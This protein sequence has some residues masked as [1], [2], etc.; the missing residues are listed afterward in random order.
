MV[1]HNNE[2]PIFFTS[3]KRA[4]DYAHEFLKKITNNY[5]GSKYI[6]IESYLS[7]IGFYLNDLNSPCLIA[8]DNLYK[9]EKINENNEIYMKSIRVNEPQM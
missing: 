9:L 7:V 5:D 3:Q 4:E 6:G 1:T 2:Q 8:E